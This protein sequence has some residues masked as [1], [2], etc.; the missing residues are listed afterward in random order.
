[1]AAV[2][3]PARRPRTVPA[4]S[5]G[6]HGSP[7]DRTARSACPSGAA[8]SG[9]GPV[10]WNVLV[11][12]L[13]PFPQAPSPTPAAPDLR[14]LRPCP[15]VRARMSTTSV[16]RAPSE[17]RGLRRLLPGVATLAL[18]WSVWAG[19]GLLSDLRRPVLAQLPGS[20][21]VGSSYRYVARP[22]DTLWSIA[23][24]LYPGADPR[25]VM[26]ELSDQLHGRPL[27]A[28]QVLVVP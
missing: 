21:R 3:D 1:M 6:R 14:R 8:R 5:A 25:P 26:D 2:T 28:G 15:E 4:R 27:E 24:R 10:S 7:A 20:V 18:L 22:G 17:A 16:R 19:A 23:S 13:V 11:S 12:E 9:A